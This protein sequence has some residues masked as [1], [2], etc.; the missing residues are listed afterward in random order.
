MQ[1]A[2]YGSDKMQ[3]PMPP[4]SATSMSTQESI[5]IRE[6]M[7][8]ALAGRV[9]PSL[10]ERA[11]AQQKNHGGLLSTAL[12]QVGVLPDE[13]RAAL[14]A[15]SGLKAA[16]LEALQTPEAS[17]AA[18]SKSNGWRLI[19]AA[20]FARDGAKILI[21]FANPSVLST[22][23]A[24]SLPAHQ[25]F[26]A[27][28]SDVARV[29]ATLG[30]AEN[31]AT[32]TGSG[33]VSSLEPAGERIGDYVLE[34]ELGAGG[35]AVVHLAKEVSTERRVALKLMNTALAKDPQFIARFVQEAKASAGLRHPNIV[36]VYA[37]GDEKGQPF[38]ASEW[39]DGG[40]LDG[41]L[42]QAGALPVA[43][44]LEI[45]SQVLEAIGYAHERG[46]VHRDL[47]P[48][49]LLMSKTGLVK[50]ADFGIAKTA[51]SAALTQ[52]GA[53]L[54]TPA[55]MSP[56]QAAGKPVDG[57][58]DLFSAGVM[59][60]EML[61]G[62]NP[63]QG[64]DPM[65]CLAKLLEPRTAPI[66]SRVADIPEAVAQL[67]DRL[68]E[69]DVAK[70]PAN[71][72]EVLTTLQP[73]LGPIRARH[74]GLL[75]R[76]VED[77]AGAS[78]ALKKQ[79]AAQLSIE[80]RALLAEGM[81]GRRKA[82]FVLYRATRLAPDDAA[83]RTTFQEL[84]AA[85]GLVASAST[86]PKVLQ[87]EE[88]LKTG[89]QPELLQQ[90]ATLYRQERNIFRAAE[91]LTQYLALNPHDGQVRATL[92]TLRGDRVGLSGS[93]STMPLSNRTT[94]PTAVAQAETASPMGDSAGQLAAGVL[95]DFF[96]YLT[97]PARRLPMV[98]L[99]VL[100]AAWFGYSQYQKQQARKAEAA[101]AAL[102][103]KEREQQ[104]ARLEQAR[105]AQEEAQREAAERN[106]LFR[107]EAQR[108]QEADEARK[109]Q[110]ERAQ[111]RQ[112]DAPREERRLRPSPTVVMPSGF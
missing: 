54:G 10:L 75:V 106:R 6:G 26:I 12:T 50:L 88:Q 47:K 73:L 90:L 97:A 78:A 61:S 38:I 64:E 13:V 92:E 91:V 36:E 27:L 80:G 55:Y 68:L 57:R 5:S 59:L 96:Q 81:A 9:S 33:T 84:L 65:S 89:P 7:L 23:H 4:G 22:P 103:E 70:R 42:E 43:V 1:T 20:P 21:A 82:A 46:I 31:G 108:Q 24:A 15:A 11:V 66:D 56:E 111:E 101:A 93:T 62:T 16:P 67:I 105:L 60:Y 87:L 109:W 100:L 58:S 69:R 98:G 35:M 34:R 104:Q 53:T 44:G 32:L 40:T 49:N 77:H 95:G 76:F 86:N 51:Q 41:M 14:A 102:H 85:E 25:P 63:H 18:M 74:P 2:P 3:L 30:Q 28:E 17:L 48:A 37:Y 72:R 79:T 71:A 94:G 83:L 52:T 110:N 29:L 99:A 19:G 39:V 107:E 8:R 45:F 112:Q